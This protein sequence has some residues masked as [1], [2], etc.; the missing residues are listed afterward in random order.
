MPTKTQE[1]TKLSSL[2]EKKLNLTVEQAKQDIIKKRLDNSDADAYYKSEGLKRY[3]C[4]VT[5]RR[6]N[7]KHF[8]LMAES[9][10]NRHKPVKIQGKLGVELEEGLP[11]YVIDR[12]QSAYDIVADEVPTNQDP[13]VFSQNTFSTRKLQRYFVRITGEVENPKVLGTNVKA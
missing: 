8:E 3:K 1:E 10:T 9:P 12:L 2:E 6:G 11:M 4:I 5:S 13:N 7:E